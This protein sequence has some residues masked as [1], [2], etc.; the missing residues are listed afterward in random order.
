MQVYHAL[1]R[2]SADINDT[3]ITRIAEAR[4]TYNTDVT[5]YCISRIYYQMTI[6]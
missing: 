3:Y 5:N 1:A 6:L 4:L 2:R